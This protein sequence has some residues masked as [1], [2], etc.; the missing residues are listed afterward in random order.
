MAL[1]SLNQLRP[2][3]LFL[4]GL[5]R[6]WLEWRDGIRIHPTASISL[7]SRFIGGQPGGITVGADTLVAF[8]TLLDARDLA[9]G[10][11]KPI[12]IGERC[13]IGGGSTILPGV[14][15]ADEVIVAA[16]A[17]VFDDVPAR[18]IV[19]G[20]PARIVRHD[21]KVGRFGRLDGANDNTR[22]MYKL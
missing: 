17:V 5:R 21:I 8:K 15:I 19:A 2:L 13:F 14:T 11:V 1:G 10:T 22:R 7:S 16:G 6:R 12:R 4:T 9:T 18:C 20:N 3:R